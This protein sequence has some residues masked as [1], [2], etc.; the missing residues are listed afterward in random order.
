MSSAVQLLVQHKSVS[1][2]AGFLTLTFLTNWGGKLFSTI[3]ILIYNIVIIILYFILESWDGW[4][5][6]HFTLVCLKWDGAF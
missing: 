2:L 5:L 4:I 1:N 3:T 6:K